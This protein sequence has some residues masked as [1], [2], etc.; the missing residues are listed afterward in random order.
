MMCLMDLIILC[1]FYMLIY[2]CLK[3]SVIKILQKKRKEP[4]EFRNK[5]LVM[6][7]QAIC[8]C[9]GFAMNWSISDQIKIL[10]S[11]YVDRQKLQMNYN[12]IKIALSK[13]PFVSKVFVSMKDTSSFFFYEEVTRVT[14]QSGLCRTN[15]VCKN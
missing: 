8:S 14:W 6:Y 10:V 7:V 9:H 11:S 4:S 3:F 12:K 2:S 13:Q 5:Q 1:S 15:Q